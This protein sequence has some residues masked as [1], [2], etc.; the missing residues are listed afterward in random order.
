MGINDSKQKTCTAIVFDRRCTNKSQK[1]L[2]KSHE[3]LKREHCKMY[4]IYREFQY[5]DVPIV[6]SAI[7][8]E[9]EAR[10]KYRN[11]YNLTLEHGHIQWE[12]YLENI[13]FNLQY[14]YDCQYDYDFSP[15]EKSMVIGKYNL[16]CKIDESKSEEVDDDFELFNKLNSARY[17]INLH[18]FNYHF[19]VNRTRLT[20]M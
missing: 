7:Q 16:S 1:S 10:L 6:Q 13:A 20:T 8:C 4:H 12:K 18:Y 9:L 5:D 17:N 19:G 2:C 15:E 14:N 11:I 3:K